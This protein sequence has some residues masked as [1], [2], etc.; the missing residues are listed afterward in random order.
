MDLRVLR[1]VVV[2][3]RLLSYTKA[4]EELHMTQSALSRSIQAIERERKVRLFDRDRG[5]VHLT[6]VGRSFAAAAAALLREADVLGRMLERS[7]DAAEGEVRLGMAPLPA[8]ALAAPL[9]S[10]LMVEKPDLRTT[11]MVR[12]V[13]TLVHELLAENIEFLICSETQIPDETQLKRSLLGWF[14]SSLLVRDKH[15]VLEAPATALDRYPFISTS[16]LTTLMRWPSYLRPFLAKPLHV[17]EDHAAVARITEKTNAIWVCSSFAAIDEIRAGRLRQLP[18]AQGQGYGSFRILMYSLDRRSL[19][20]AALHVK[21]SL[22]SIIRTLGST[23][24]DGTLPARRTAPRRER[25]V[26]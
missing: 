8:K 18:A 24:K 16:A 11:V 19:S 21:S 14:P 5:G 17:V 7:A 13:D 26:E 20:P 10:G 15:P 9:L 3:S 2:L 1:H 6:V 12:G 23:H 4:A 25:G 22:Q